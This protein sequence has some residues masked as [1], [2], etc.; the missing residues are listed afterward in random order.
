LALLTDGQRVFAQYG[1]AGNDLIWTGRPARGLRLRRIDALLIPFSLM[2]GGF[3]IFWESL[4]VAGRAPL[5]FA[6]WGIPFVLVGL[7]LIA[8]R[9]AW[10]AYV[11]SRT[12]YAVTSDSALIC[13]QMPGGGLQHI[14]LQSVNNLRLQV[15][16]D[17]TGTISFGNEVPW[18]WGGWQGWNGPAV[19]S[20]E[21]IA[22]ARRVYDM[23]AQARR[24]R[25]VTDFPSSNSTES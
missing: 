1:E 14:Y 10:D 20:F 8:G 13:R 19:P 16:Q 9:F 12:W 21:F 5:F 11:R 2:W 17:G 3:A 4:A 25:A 6:L 15:G 24:R 22:D 7:Y 23:C 18:G